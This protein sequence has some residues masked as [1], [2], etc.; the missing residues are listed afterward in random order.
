VIQLR[1][2]TVVLVSTLA[3]VA[4]AAG[5]IAAAPAANAASAAKVCAVPRGAKVNV[6]G[7][8]GI[9]YNVRLRKR[10]TYR[11]H[12]FFVCSKLT[13]RR[14]KLG[15]VGDPCN[16]LAGIAPLVLAGTYLA[17]VSTDEQCQEAG[18]TVYADGHLMDLRTGASLPNPFQIVEGGVPA[19][20]LVLSQDGAMG[21]IA[22]FYNHQGLKVDFQVWESD[23][24]GAR[25]LASGPGIAP[26]SLAL[27]D[28]TLSWSDG[29]QLQSTPIGPGPATRARL[30]L[31]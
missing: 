22:R 28:T 9:V 29:G 1:R 21:W 6:E 13:G 31:G 8:S 16:E 10:H 3:A 14:V 4:G 5:M 12:A 23:A 2:R 24:S 20:G 30:P 19:G 26:A 11:E 27:T 15:V 18:E 7:T 25:Q 17:W